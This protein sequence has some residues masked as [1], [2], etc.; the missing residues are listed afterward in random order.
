MILGHSPTPHKNILHQVFTRGILTATFTR[1][2]PDQRFLILSVSL[3]ALNIYIFY[4]FQ[5]NVVIIRPQKAGTV[6]VFMLM[7]LCACVCLQLS[8]KF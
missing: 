4:D 8:D 7:S 3:N 5:I 6:I 2:H 1:P